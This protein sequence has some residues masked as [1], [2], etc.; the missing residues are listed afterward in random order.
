MASLLGRQVSAPPDGPFS[1]P[2]YGKPVSSDGVP[3]GLQ[4]I[5]SGP[6]GDS[7]G[8]VYLDESGRS[9]KI[10]G[11]VHGQHFLDEQ[12]KRV[13]QEGRIRKRLGLAIIV[14]SQ[15]ILE[16]IELVP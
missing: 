7:G 5:K 9:V 4:Q 1:S 10:I 8:P 15:A 3:T 11:L 16:A 14:N 12:F 2:A 6:R 13:Y